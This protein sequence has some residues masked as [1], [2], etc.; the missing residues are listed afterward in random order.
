MLWLTPGLKKVMTSHY[1][2]SYKNPWYLIVWQI[3]FF[4]YIMVQ[5]CKN[6]FINQNRQKVGKSQLVLW[7]KN[8]LKL[9]W[10][11]VI[12]NSVVNEH[13][14]ITNRFLEQI[15]LC[16]TQVDPVITNPGYNEQKWPARAVRY[17][18][19]WLYTIYTVNYWVLII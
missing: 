15:C 5:F 9:Q 11:S 18:R 2:D 14:V 17:S 3:F 1:G 12:T 8:N 10:N 6:E 19:V 7:K 16:T 4:D 13:S